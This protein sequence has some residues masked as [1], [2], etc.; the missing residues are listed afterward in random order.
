VLLAVSCALVAVPFLSVQYPPITDL[1]Q[2]LAQIRLF[3]EA[4]A[5]PD[6]PYR[7]Q[8]FTPYLLGYLPLE[9]AWRL[10]PDVTA[11]RIAMLILALLWTVGIH[12]LAVRRGRPASAAVLASALFYNHATYWGFYSFVVGFPVFVLWFL[13]TT[14]GAATRFRASDAVLYLGVAALLYLSHALWLAAGT[15]WLLLRIAVARPPLRTAIL[16]LASFA[17]VLIGAAIWYRQ[18]T[19]FSSP[20]RWIV[21]PS[22]RLSFSW[23]VDST[24][25]GLQG[26]IEYGLVAFL[27][28]WIALGLAQSRD[29]LHECVDRDLCLAA[30]L[31]TAMVF[32]LPNLHQNTIA[33]A[34]RWQPVAAIMLLLALPPPRWDRRLRD[35]TALAVVAAFTVVTSLGWMRVERDEYDGL[36]ESLAALPPNPRVIGLDYVKTSA[37]VKGRPFLQGFAYAQV[38]RGGQLN[39]SFAEF[40]PMAVVYKAPTTPRRWT[41]GLEW[42]AEQATPAD[43]AQFEYALVNGER[44]QHASVTAWAGLTPLTGEGRWRLYRTGT[45]AR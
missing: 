25:G 5:D 24:L 29:R 17:P 35:A 45:S 16:Q 28:L 37:T 34:A 4:L 2:H 41:R 8:W 11:G 9:A 23:I 33:F 39:F 40:A 19:G 42:A 7:I 22:G 30:A 20:T 13:L 3:H 21:T 18:M 44:W 27:A 14:R 15:A 12:G 38:L 6:G 31:F 32:A 43:V 36:T 1:P 10:S 26:P